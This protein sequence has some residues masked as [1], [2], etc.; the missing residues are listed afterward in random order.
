MISLVTTFQYHIHLIEGG[1]QTNHLNQ[2][3]GN[4]PLISESSDPEIFS[5]HATIDSLRVIW[6][7]RLKGSN[8]YD[9]DFPVD[10]IQGSKSLLRGVTARTVS[11]RLCDKI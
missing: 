4:S 2:G 6:R 3:M 11:I 1:I 9:V 10:W 5:R 8:N 7:P